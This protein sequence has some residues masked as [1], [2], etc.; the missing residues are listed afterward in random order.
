MSNWIKR[1][2]T[3]ELANRG[4]LLFIAQALE[5]FGYAHNFKVAIETENSKN[6]KSENRFA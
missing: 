3:D 4:L 1:S 5:G 6:Y 2:I